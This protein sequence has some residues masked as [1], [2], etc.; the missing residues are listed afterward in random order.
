MEFVL[1]TVSGLKSFPLLESAPRGR[2]RL[3]SFFQRVCL[4]GLGSTVEAGRGVGRSGRVRKTRRIKTERFGK[5]RFFGPYP[6]KSEKNKGSTLCFLRKSEKNKGN[7]LCFLPFFC[8]FSGQPCQSNKNV[9]SPMYGRT[10]RDTLKS[11]Y[12]YATFFGKATEVAKS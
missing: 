8:F 7:T 11:R 4:G 1:R 3:Q 12:P 5:P 2:R 10:E 9:N 6:P